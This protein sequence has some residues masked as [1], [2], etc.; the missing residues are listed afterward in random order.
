MSSCSAAK[1]SLMV[2]TP[3]YTRE[4]LFVAVERHFT[5]NGRTGNQGV[6]QNVEITESGCYHIQALGAEG[7]NSAGGKYKGGVGARVTAREILSKNTIL[8]IVV[9]HHG[10]DGVRN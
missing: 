5:T 7:G 10:G 8:N 6:I 2:V 9:G 4:D 3:H 1:V